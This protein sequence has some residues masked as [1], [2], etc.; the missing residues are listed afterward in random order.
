MNLQRAAEI[1]VVLEGVSLPATRAQLV[2]YAALYDDAAASEL[3][4]IA[5]REYRRIDE[6][7]EEL[8]ATQAVRPP[9]QRLPKPESGKP[10]GGDDY[11][12]P[13]PESGAVRHDAP[14]TNPPQKAIEQQTK[15]Q[16]RQ[17]AAQGS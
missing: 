7:G 10:P 15:T 3:R 8:V 14:R 4:S 1:Q 16:K 9:S 5:D 6:V 17:Q 12:R 2:D 13:F 11:L